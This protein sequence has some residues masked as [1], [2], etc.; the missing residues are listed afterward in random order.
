MYLA[1]AFIQSDILIVYYNYMKMS[2]SP[3]IRTQ[4]K[5]IP[6][7]HTNHL[8]KSFGRST[9]IHYNSSFRLTVSLSKLFQSNT[10][11]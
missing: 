1:D 11:K 5:S 10:W 8:P 4:G 2:A 7:M 6:V 9:N 3:R